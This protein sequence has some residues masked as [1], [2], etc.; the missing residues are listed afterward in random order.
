MYSQCSL[1]RKLCVCFL[2]LFYD[3]ASNVGGGGVSMEL[4]E[5]SGEERPGRISYFPEFDCRNL[6][7]NV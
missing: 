1:R 4:L 7:E 6:R 2:W 3:A 5:E